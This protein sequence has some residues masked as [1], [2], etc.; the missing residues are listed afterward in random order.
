MICGKPIENVRTLCSED[1]RP[2]AKAY[3]GR[4]EKQLQGDPVRVIGKNIPRHDP[5]FYL[6]DLNRTPIVVE[7]S[8]GSPFSGGVT[9]YYI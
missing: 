9:N 8:G 1:E 5:G 2:E 3:I 6:Y 7:P 4:I